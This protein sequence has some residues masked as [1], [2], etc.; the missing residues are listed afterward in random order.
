M[1]ERQ[2]AISPQAAAAPADREAVGVVSIADILL[3][4]PDE[5]WQ[6]AQ[7]RYDLSGGQPV[8]IVAVPGGYGVELE[9][10]VSVRLAIVA[11]IETP[12]QRLERE[13]A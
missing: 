9:A 12:A 1:A 13:A 2:A 4:I 5:V 10:N 8:A 11:V 3:A 7:A 6:R